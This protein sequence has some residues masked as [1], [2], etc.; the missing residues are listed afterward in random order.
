M[1][2]SAP[3]GVT[4]IDSYDLRYIDSSSSAADK[5]DD[6]NW[7]V[8]DPAWTAGSLR[9]IVV[10]LANSTPSDPVSYDVQ[11]RAVTTS[12]GDWSSTETGKPREPSSS[13]LN[14]TAI[15][16]ELPVRGVLDSSRDYDWFQFS[17]SEEREYFILT[18][19]DTDTYGTLYRGVNSYIAGNDDSG[20][21]S[22]SQNFKLDGKLTAGTYYIEVTGVGDATGDYT[23]YLQTAA[24]TTGL[25]D[26]TPIELDSVTGAVL[27]DT[28]ATL[29]IEPGD[30]DYFKLELTTAT[31]IT[32]RASGF[33][34]DTV[35]TI[36]SADGMVVASNDDAY[37]EPG[38]LQFA[39]RATLGVGT[40]YIRVKPFHGNKFG[41]YFLY[42]YE[43]PEP[44]NSRASAAAIDIS[45]T[46]GGTT[47]AAGDY[48]TFTLDESTRVALV[49]SSRE[50]DIKA[51]VQ[52]STGLA[53]DV[54]NYEV[55]FSGGVY[56]F[57]IFDTLAAG[58]YYLRV[59]A[60]QFG[61]TGKY[62]VLLRRDSG[63]AYL[64]QICPSAPAGI[65]DTFYGCQ[66]H[67]NNT[68]QFGSTP[69][70]DINID[71]ATLGSVWN[72]TMGFRC[73]RR[74]G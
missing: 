73:Q 23:L 68:G 2:W 31:T 36:F 53:L 26:A 30:T 10:G 67:L 51:T 16:N 3:A 24:D 12:E 39:V 71:D 54:S 19:G 28:G 21:S 49:G 15:V 72:T 64:E 50:V 38:R 11:V 63:Y 45:Q 66:W 22:G 70:E 58:T 1:A 35:G 17:V 5:A 48:F 56:T 33:V 47:D 59:D 61:D 6:A 34:A 60:N 40:Y 9:V 43:S 65:N 29:S 52:D 20:L 57:A 74:G 18:T 55:N 25:S 8:L 69:D 7:T 27:H 41:L 42:V 13:R 46:A 62:L 4:G 14:A 32:A 37:L 44:G